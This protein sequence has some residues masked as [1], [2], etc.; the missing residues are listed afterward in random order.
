MIIVLQ[1]AKKGENDSQEC[2][3]KQRNKTRETEIMLVAFSLS[4]AFIKWCPRESG[5]EKATK[6]VCVW[7]WEKMF[8][9]SESWEDVIHYFTRHSD[10]VTDAAN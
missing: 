2:D 9:L 4:S 8:I 6:Q 7:V 5:S 1:A 10:W 3:M